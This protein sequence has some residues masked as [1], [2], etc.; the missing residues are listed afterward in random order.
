[1]QD[2]VGLVMPRILCALANEACFAIMEG[3]A[4]A[5]DIDTAMKLGTNYP[6]GPVV[7]AGRIGWSQVL[8]VLKGL[9]GYFGEDRY[10]PAPLLQRMAASCA[11]GQ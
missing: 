8:A 9:H 1:V 2:S 3:V 5:N 4:E 10:R 7:W 11:G 6:S